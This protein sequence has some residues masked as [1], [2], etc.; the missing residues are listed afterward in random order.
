[1]IKKAAY[2]LPQ[3]CTILGNCNTFLVFVWY[4]FLAMVTKLTGHVCQKGIGMNHI[5]TPTICVI[6]SGPLIPPLQTEII[7][8]SHL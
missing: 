6:L 7:S 1:M 4:Q 2:A 8:T 3:V 5:C